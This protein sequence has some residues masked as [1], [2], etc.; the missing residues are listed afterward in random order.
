MEAPAVVAGK[1]GSGAELTGENGFSFP[2]VGHFSRFDPF[3]LGLFIRV[4]AGL[5]RG[6]LVHHSKAP[7]DA[8]SRG[9]EVVLEEGRLAFGLHHMWPGNSVKV[10]T[11]RPV[12]VDTWV[13]VAVTYDGSSRAAGTRVY[14]DGLPAP[15]RVV[16][17]GLVK[18]I[19]Y[20][21]VGEPDLAIGFRFRD[22]GFQGGRVD[23]FRLFDRALTPIEVAD[24][25]GLP[26]LARA[27]AVPAA[28]LTPDQWAALGALYQATAAPGG[29]RAAAELHALRREL[30]QLVEP[31]AEIMV[32]RELATPR[33]TRVLLR[34][35]YDAPGEAVVANTPASLPPFP[36]DQPRNRLGLARWLFAPDH[37][38]TARVA[39]NRL[40]QMMWGR[41]LVETSE[42]LGRQGTPPTHADLLDWLAVE[43]VESGWDV[44]H[45]LRLIAS[46]A[47]YRQTSQADQALL[48]RD[49]A[50]RLLARG[51]VRKLTAEMIRD[52][53]L[54]VSG[55]LD[56][57][58]G[59]PPVRPYQPAGL[60][61]VASGG[62]YQQSHGADLHR[63]SLYTFWKRSVPH[64]AMLI[65]DAAD[66]NNCSM[67]RQSTSTPLQALALL[68]DPQIVEAARHLAERAI[69]NGSKDDRARAAWMFRQVLGRS[70]VARETDLLAQLLAEQR[71]HFAAEPGAAVQLL[72]VGEA[73]PD[74]TIDPVELAACTVL[75]QALLNHDAAVYRR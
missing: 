51:P 31:I 28:E 12:P 40:W 26:D 38:L 50:N 3:S 70:P 69:Q 10:V 47:T 18:D 27:W 42:N 61:D 44:R 7:I 56:E 20:G 41:G 19:G 49:P 57:T 71:H 15:T 46:S 21:A 35:A 43:F 6:V 62:G 48:A 68:N 37:P 36:A 66:R 52:N 2:G 24:L 5:T 53:A 58:K 72:G 73:R 17:D 29:L 23:E 65:F 11:E 60:Y 16:R 4:P 33:P 1:V 75:A 13:H 64:P 8:G 54:G 30:G 22:S 55:L 39:V 59:G 67:R 34:G 32:M 63:R 9:Y 74:P 45:I 25:A 14:L